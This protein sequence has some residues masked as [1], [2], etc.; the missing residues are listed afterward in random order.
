MKLSM[1]KWKICP[2]GTKRLLALSDFHGAPTNRTGPQ[3]DFSGRKG[4]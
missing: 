1:S 2:S 4:M 3:E